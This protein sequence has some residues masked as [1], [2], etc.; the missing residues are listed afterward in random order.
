MTEEIPDLVAMGTLTPIKDLALKNED[1]EDYDE[2]FV[3]QRC[4]DVLTRG[5]IAMSA[6]D[7]LEPEKCPRIKARG[8]F[9]RYIR[10]SPY[11]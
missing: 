6:Q 9:T 8:E 2:G 7:M 4:P 10:F 5:H 3:H 1:Q 11:V